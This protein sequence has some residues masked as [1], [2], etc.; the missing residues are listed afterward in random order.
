MQCLKDKKPGVLLGVPGFFLSF[1]EVF[2][3]FLRIFAPISFP[4]KVV[5]LKFGQSLQA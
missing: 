1:Y 3:K 5:R 2:S 4:A